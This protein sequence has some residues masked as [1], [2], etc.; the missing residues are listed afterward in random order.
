MGTTFQFK[1][2]PPVIT[3]STLFIATSMEIIEI[4]LDDA[5]EAILFYLE[6]LKRP[7]KFFKIARRVTRNKPVI[8]LKG[9][10]TADGA[11]A[12]V[13]HTASLGSD[14]RILDG[15]VRQSGIV[16]IHE[17]SHLVLA[18]K[19]IEPMPVSYTH[20]TLPTILLV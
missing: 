1:I 14:D 7:S 19:A 12:A 2:A 5:T 20:L 6:S 3:T 17:F 15:A 10:S 8:L 13:S 9:G 4:S 18:A 16:R 11:S